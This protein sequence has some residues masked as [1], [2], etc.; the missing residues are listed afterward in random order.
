MRRTTYYVFQSATAP[1][2]RGITG[3]PDGSEAPRH[4]WTVDPGAADRSG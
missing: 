3:D 1:D 2:L 4:G